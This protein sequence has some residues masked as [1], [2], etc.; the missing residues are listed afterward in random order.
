MKLFTPRIY[1]CCILFLFGVFPFI[2]FSQTGPGG[3]QQTNGSSELVLWLDAS[4]LGLSDGANVSLWTDISGYGNSATSSGS[5]R[6]KFNASWQNAQP[7]VQFFNASEDFMSILNSASTQ[8][9][10]HTIYIVADYSSSSDEWAPFVVKTTNNIWDDGWGIGR[11]S[12]DE[13]IICF[14]D[15]YADF[16]IQNFQNYNSAFLLNHQKDGTNLNFYLGGNK[17]QDIAN[18]GFTNSTSPMLLGASPDDFGGERDFLD[19][20]I[21][22]I[23]IFDDNLRSSERILVDNY[24]SSKYGIS[25]NTDRYA[26]D[27][28]HPYQVFGIGRKNNSNNF[29]ATS[30]G[31][32]IVEISNPS[33]LSDEDFLLIGHDNAGLTANYN[34]PN[35]YSYRLDRTWRVD[36]TGN[37]GTLTVS[38]DVTGLGL[39]TDANEYALLIDTDGDFADATI[40]T[41]GANYSGD[42]ITFTGVNFADGNYFSLAPYS[43]IT[44]DGVAY[45]F[46]SG[47]GGVPNNFDDDRKLFVFAGGASISDNCKVKNLVLTGAGS[48]TI[49]GN[50]SL[51][52][53]EEIENNGTV[54]VE[55]GSGL[56]QKHSGLNGNSGSGNYV[57]KRTGVSSINS[58]NGF[59]SPVSAANLMSVFSGSNA[60][61]IY[62]FDGASQTWKYDFTSGSSAMCK[63]NTVTFGPTDVISSGNGVMDVGRGYF[64]P[65]SGVSTRQFSGEV[66]N[67]DLT[68]PINVATNPGGVSWEGD[69]FNLVGNP[70]PSSIDAVKFWNENSVNNSRITNAIYFWD[71]ADAGGSYNQDDE[72]AYW[73]P[74]GGTSS[75]NSGKTPNGRIGSSQGFFVVAQANTSVVFTND[76]RRNGNNQFF[77]T[78]N[79]LDRVRFWI[80]A[81]NTVGDYCQILLGLDDNSTLG[82]D[83]G[84]DAVR[85]KI[86]SKMQMGTL[87]DNNS[88]V[89]QT[90][91]HITNQDYEDIPL[92]IRSSEYGVHV[93]KL[94]SI[95]DPDNRY[96]V[97]IYDNVFGKVYPLTNGIASFFLGANENHENRFFIRV[98][99]NINGIENATLKSDNLFNAWMYEN[100]LFVS[101]EYTN[102]IERIE[103]YTISGSHIWSKTET[104][105]DVASG[106]SIPELVAGVYILKLA[107]KDGTFTSIKVV[108]P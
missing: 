105:M 67:G 71:D 95:E 17:V 85:T 68:M 59:S 43:S 15:D 20:N 81:E 55:S 106:I 12:S 40:H 70:Y 73:I 28:S 4:N 56:V 24:L 21:A 46:G 42:I 23:I 63:S 98:G 89:I 102:E 107:L 2:G 78:E 103:L 6:P 39:P 57:V 91:P 37:V 76:M 7:A 36:E 41:T 33:S 8:F 26:Y 80:N 87:V 25:I 94:D 54:T 62:A 32:G 82:M 86:S 100:A 92:N 9:D 101:G 5:D 96:T 50:R 69:D 65:G 79:T 16:G 53:E 3:V 51:T 108:Q 74:A 60:C 31:Q 99:T 14:V 66:N 45:E 35:E 52:V 19:G 18:A 10:H 97:S 11:Y 58:F 88:C 83:N 93:L 75:S 1:S 44:W 84:Y 34:T 77:K 47:M 48:L 72:F 30:Q 22:E 90:R 49:S 29:I 13:E 64:V 61:D 104:N 27:T 38:F